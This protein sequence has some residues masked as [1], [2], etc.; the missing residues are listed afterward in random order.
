MNKNTMPG[1]I[2]L[3]FDECPFPQQHSSPAPGGLGLSLTLG[4]MLRRR[5]GDSL[6]LHVLGDPGLCQQTPHGSFFPGASC[7]LP[8]L[9]PGHL[10]WGQ[11]PL[12]CLPEPLVCLKH[13]WGRPSAVL[14]SCSFPGDA[15]PHPASELSVG[16]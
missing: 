14:Q 2:Y 12:S 13:R 1:I 3:G 16:S 10:P 5:G 9:V 15:S 8:H 6:Y 11:L 7:H 4:H